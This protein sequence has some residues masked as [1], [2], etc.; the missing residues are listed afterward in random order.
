MTGSSPSNRKA[1]TIRSAPTD[2]E[3]GY[4]KPPQ[5]T[6]FKPGRS[7]N[8]KGRPKGANRLPALN[9]ERLKT[10]I[11]E[12]AYRQIAVS[13]GSRSVSIPMA[14]AVVRSIAVNAAKGNSRAQRLFAEMLV[15]T[16]R[17][18]TAIDYKNHWEAELERRQ[19]LGIDASDPIPHPDHI[20][21][22]TQT[23]QVRI[24]GRMTREEKKQWDWL[25][26]RKVEFEAELDELRQMLIDDPNYPHRKLVENDI[27]HTG[28]ILEIIRRS[29]PN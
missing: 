4:A 14:Q 20:Q 19:R 26:K 9:D 23:G 18:K 17:E 24:T 25:V 5:S 29:V 2:Y 16:E 12:E 13:E 1:L 15:M 28:K 8:P 22:D 11:M 21:I 27:Q 6:R 3:V 10:T 7:R